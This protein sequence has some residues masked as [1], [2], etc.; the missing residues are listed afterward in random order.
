MLDPSKSKVYLVGGGVASLAAAVFLIRDAGVPGRNIQ[1]FEQLAAPGGLLEGPG[2]RGDVTR[3]GRPWSAEHDV[4]LA[5]LL[6]TIPSP[7]DPAAS[8][9][10][11]DAA[12]PDTAEV[13]IVRRDRSAPDGPRLAARDRADLDRLAALP[14][15]AIG[16]SRID[17]YVR[18]EF[19]DSDFWARWRACFALQPWHSAIEL[20]RHLVSCGRAHT[21][22]GGCRGSHT[23]CDSLVL[24]MQRWLQ[25]CGVRFDFN[26][27][28]EDIDFRADADGRHAT[29]L[30]LTRSDGTPRRIPLGPE[31]CVFVTNGSMTADAAH[32]DSHT[33]PD[34]IRTRR[35]GSWRLWESLARKASDFGRP[36]VFCDDIDR[37]R[38]ESFT[39]T[40]SDRTLLDRLAVAPNTVT[41][42]RD[43]AWQ[44]SA[45]M[46]AQPHFRDQRPGTHTLWGY[47]LRADAPGDFVPKPM[48]A[49]TGAQILDELLGHLGC[50]DIA[51]RVRQATLV[52]TTQMPYAGAALQPRTLADRPLVVPE[53]A[54]NFAFV[55]QFVEIPEVVAFTA[56]YSVRSAMMAVYHHF[57]VDAA[58]PSPLR[59]PTEAKVAWFAPG[60]TRVPG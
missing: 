48:A 56:E 20:R 54:R 16:A 9:W 17:D 35:D 47:G 57:G 49:C 34:L 30:Y 15:H 43:S 6:S 18:P 60:V 31:D 10:V 24:P 23:Q 27:T 45:T 40:L 14:E 41:T 22:A 32:G 11:S 2:E 29:M 19:F 12:G 42:F 52:T 3:G 1:V 4:C 7:D 26:V 38:W 50:E 39:L 37:T 51:A 33:V 53:G 55:G 46:P 8:V 58:I 25:A 59:S 28:V 44:L 21:L 36:S 5:N 13:R